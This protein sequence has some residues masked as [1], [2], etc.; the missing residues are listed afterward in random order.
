[1]SSRGAQ[2]A[3]EEL[4]FQDLE[5]FAETSDDSVAEGLAFVGG[6]GPG[7]LGALPSALT[8][9]V[10]M[11]TGEARGAELELGKRGEAAAGEAVTFHPCTDGAHGV[12]GPGSALADTVVDRSDFEKSPFELRH[13]DLQPP[14]GMESIASG[15]NTYGRRE[16]RRPIET[17]LP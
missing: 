2:G 12:R 17:M 16:R 6:E 5:F 10:S 4:G 8:D 1:M 13:S 7:E 11:P 3:S 14:Q 9:E 15:S